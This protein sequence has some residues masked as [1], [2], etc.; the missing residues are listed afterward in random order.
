MDVKLSR[1][2]FAGDEKIFEVLA[3]PRK[4]FQYGA[5]IWYAT[6]M[7]GRFNDI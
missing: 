1:A 3:G 4:S 5:E 7:G 2:M 6:G